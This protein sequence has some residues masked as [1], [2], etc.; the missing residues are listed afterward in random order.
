M[1]TMESEDDSDMLSP[2][3]AGGGGPK[4][5]EEEEEEEVDLTAAADAAATEVAGMPVD[6]TPTAWLGILGKMVEDEKGAAVA[7]TAKE[8]D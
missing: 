6:A 4:E 1:T 8:E 3:N 5:E 7:V 2:E